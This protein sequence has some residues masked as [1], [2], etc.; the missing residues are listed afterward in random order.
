[1]HFKLPSTYNNSSLQNVVKK[2]TK[3][4]NMSEIDKVRSIFAWLT[5]RDMT[6]YDNQAQL[7]DSNVQYHLACVNKKDKHIAKL[8]EEMCR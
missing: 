5:T 1:M 6:K 2:L 8:F 4:R 3:H 7:N